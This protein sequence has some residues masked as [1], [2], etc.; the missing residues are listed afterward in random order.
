MREIKVFLPKQVNTHLFVYTL[1]VY[2][3][4]KTNRARFMAQSIYK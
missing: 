2:L 1:E 4:A 3:E